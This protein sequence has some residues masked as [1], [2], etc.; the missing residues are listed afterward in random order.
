MEA[1]KDPATFEAFVNKYIY[2][3]KN[4]EEYLELKG[5]EKRL[6]ELRALEPLR[7]E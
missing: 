5:G 6:A 7:R 2:G 1:E 4:F 3:T